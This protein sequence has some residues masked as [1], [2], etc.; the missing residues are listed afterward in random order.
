MPRKRKPIALDAYEKL[1]ERYAALV[2]DKAENAHY[3]MPATLSVLPHV[4]GM[5][6]LDAGCG[7]GRYTEWLL[8]HGAE[9]MGVDASPRMIRQAR[10]RVAKRAEFHIADLGKPIDFLENRSFD[11]V[12]APL[13][14]DYIEDWVPLFKGFNRVLKG[15]GLLVFS[16]GHPFADYD[17]H[18]GAD[19]F[20][21]E[22]VEDLWKGFGIPVVVP[23]Y[24]RPIGLVLASLIE[25][26]FTL[27]RF[28]EPRA[29][30]EVRKRDPEAY[31]RRHRLPGFIAVRARKTTG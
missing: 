29:G 25:T 20:T 16:C 7:T 12:L 19:Y 30:D 1:A 22:Y 23:C 27:E 2:D 26:G 4:G 10:K 3:E 17:R 11:L 31:E 9:V 28:L 24:R 5:R 21:T 13:V 15:F 18:P 6:V 14:L 8:D